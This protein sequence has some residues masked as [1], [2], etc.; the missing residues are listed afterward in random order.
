MSSE[1]VACHCCD[2]IVEVSTLKP[3]CKAHC[4]R[5]GH[6]LSSQTA[7]AYNKATAFAASA[8][9][10]L[11]LS[12]PFPFMAFQSQG[13]EQQVSL[14]QS[15]YDLLIL[16]FPLLALLLSVFILIVPSLLLCAY[17]LI[18][19]PLRKNTAYPWSYT[20]ARLIFTLH[21]WAMAEV[22]LIGVLVSLVKISG[23]AD[24][25]IGM[26]F[27]AYVLFAL[28]LIATITCIDRL[29]LWHSLD[30]ASSIQRTPP[31]HNYGG[32]MQQQLQSCH[33]CGLI[34]HLDAH[35]CQRCSSS[36]HP[37]IPAS[38]QKTWAFLITG[39][40][41]YIPANIY[42]IMHTRLLGADEPSTIL[43]G[44][45]L[46][47]QHGSYPIALIVF[48]ASILIPIVKMLALF[49][50]ALSVQAGHQNRVSE[51]I[52]MYRMTELIGRWSMIDV[53]VVAVLVALV[54]LG[55]LASILPGIAVTAFAG[56]VILTMLS[57][58]NFDPRLIW[59]NL[60]KDELHIIKS[61]QEPLN[62]LLDEIN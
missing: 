19:I 6:L 41:L 34:H 49:W 50:L 7:N 47:W 26:S 56:V 58:I 28:C 53:F 27:W 18:L 35:N 45:V 46:L 5:C 57:A 1:N 36:L 42:P 22:F 54:Q 14:I 43:G 30:K 25:V 39:A 37:R 24:L 15:G 44:V 29:Q 52:W 2:L 21:P 31:K 62:D 17:L 38:L 40:L 59:D 8:L 4:P 9:L 23:M 60:D 10:F 51:R 3:G 48:I 33:C 61:G 20:L 16:G 11:L 13:R 32:A 55:G 12:L